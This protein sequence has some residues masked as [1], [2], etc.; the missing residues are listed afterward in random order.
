MHLTPLSLMSLSNRSNFLN[1]PREKSGKNNTFFPPYKC[2]LSLTCCD[3]SVRGAR[4]HYANQA[5]GRAS[6][7]APLIHPE[8]KHLGKTLVS[9]EDSA[10]VLAT[11]SATASPTLCFDDRKDIKAQKSRPVA[12]PGCSPS[13][14]GAPSPPPRR[15]RGAEL[16]AASGDDKDLVQRL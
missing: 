8:N 14:S 11:G 2:K 1:H 13:S 6:S 15:S 3:N 10:L 5:S 12:P 16:S 4:R 9:A 7:S